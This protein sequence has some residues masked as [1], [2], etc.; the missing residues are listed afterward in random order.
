M[1]RK[2]VKLE[3]SMRKNFFAYALLIVEA[4]T[5]T[6]N[7]KNFYLINSIIVLIIAILYMKE[8]AAFIAK[9]IG[10]KDAKRNI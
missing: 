9:I 7:I 8:I 4:L 3:V 1:V 6:V 10:K 5:V 2:Y